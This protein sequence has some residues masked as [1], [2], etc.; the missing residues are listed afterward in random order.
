MGES[1]DERSDIY[2]L[3]AV[4]FEM[5]SGRE[6]FTSVSVYELIQKH[7]LC[8]P[9]P[10]ADG[11]P[12]ISVPL[13]LEK[14]VFKALSKSP[15]NRHQSIR[16]LKISVLNACSA[17]VNRDSGTRIE[18]LATHVGSS[19]DL[20]TYV[21]AMAPYIVSKSPGG[22]ECS[23]ATDGTAG[24]KGDTESDIVTDGKVFRNRIRY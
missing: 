22:T 4:M 23:T 9:P 8:S 11:N 3:G 13:A 24:Q 16:E 19:N 17:D 14:V 12:N 20:L 10:I 1:G 15:A 7:L 2:S 6:P 5:L 18:Q 21:N